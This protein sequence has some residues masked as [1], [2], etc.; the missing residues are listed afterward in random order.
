MTDEIKETEV[1][2]PKKTKKQ[3]KKISVR[4]IASNEGSSLVEYLKQGEVNR[5]YIPVEE[6]NNDEASPEIL[7]AGILYG[8]DL[9]GIVSQEVITALHNYGI[10]TKADI[11]GDREQLLNALLA[12]YIRPALEKL[13]EFAGK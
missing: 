9:T 1:I 10:W 5:C 2:E 6:I 11:L 4:V 3:E 8:V 7:E 12:A 13:T